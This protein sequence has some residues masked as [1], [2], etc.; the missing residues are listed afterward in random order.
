[1]TRNPYEELPQLPTFSLTSTDFSD[2]QILPPAQVGRGYG[3]RD[4]SPQLTWNGFPA[5]TRSFALTAYDPDAPTAAGFWHWAVANVPVSVTGLATGAEPPAGS[6]SLR[7]DGG[8]RDYIGAAP[9]R[10]HG[11]HH[12][13]FAVHAVDVPTLKLSSHSSPSALGF[14]LF[15]HAIARATLVGTFEAPLD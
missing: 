10:G 2:G 6:L 9:P 15:R 11:P 8:V 4:L 7:N 5:A 14:Q 1:M 3:G 12:Y 13:W